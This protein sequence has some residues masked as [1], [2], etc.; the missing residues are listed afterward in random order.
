MSKSEHI[1]SELLDKACHSRAQT[2]IEHVTMIPVYRD[3]ETGRL[4]LEP[5]GPLLGQGSI[6]P[7]DRTVHIRIYDTISEAIAARKTLESLGVAERCMHSQMR[8]GEGC[9]LVEMARGA[10]PISLEDMRLDDQRVFPATLSTDWPRS[11]V[12]RFFDAGLDSCIDPYWR[13]KKLAQ[14]CAMSATNSVVMASCQSALES[15]PGARIA[16]DAISAEMILEEIEDNLAMPPET[17]DIPPMPSLFS[18]HFHLRSLIAS[19][20]IDRMPDEKI[21]DRIYRDLVTNKK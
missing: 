8:S 9:L 19:G 4:S 15:I 11:E 13:G 7:E 18:I 5:C 14:I 6:L 21:V 10:T 17:E 16:L 2:G 20:R 12:L 1:I 3:K